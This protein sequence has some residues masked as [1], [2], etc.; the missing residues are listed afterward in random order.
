MR[1]KNEL[2]TV[3]IDDK[4]ECNF[5]FEENAYEDEIKIV[6]AIFNLEGIKEQVKDG[7]MTILNQVSITCRT[8]LVREVFVT[9]SSIY[10]PN[11]HSGQ[12][13][14]SL[15]RNLEDINMTFYTEYVVLPNLDFL[16]E[17]MAL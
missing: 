4:I 7:L 10:Y 12:P 11:E 15:R 5:F 14:P 9:V 16:I 2:I 13:R 6:T 3:V 8:E 1:N 17:N